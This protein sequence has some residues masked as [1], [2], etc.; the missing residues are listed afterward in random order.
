MKDNWKNGKFKSRKPWNTGTTGIVKIW[1][2]GLKGYLC[3]EKHYNWKGGRTRSQWKKEN[4]DKVN[5]S[6]RLRRF[7]L[8]GSNGTHSLKEWNDLKEKYNYMCLCCGV[9]EPD[10]ILTEDHI[11]PIFLNGDNTIENIQPLCRSCNSKKGIKIINFKKQMEDQLKKKIEE[12]EANFKKI[13]EEEVKVK[14]QLEQI[15]QEEIRL[16]GEY[17]AVQSL[18]PETGE[19][20]V[21]EEIK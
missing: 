4:K 11:V 10:I 17:R 21:T 13:Q 7:K 9:K 1:N 3:K 15:M 20:A 18:M 8:G 12:I 2:K 5:H 19:Q 6:T 14:Q 16:Q